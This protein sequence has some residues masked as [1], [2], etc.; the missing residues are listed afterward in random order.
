LVVGDELGTI[1]IVDL[2]SASVLHSQLISLNE[3]LWISLVQGDGLELVIASSNRLMKIN[4]K[5]DSNSILQEN[6]ESSIQSNI[7]KTDFNNIS[8][9]QGFYDV[10]S[11]YF[12]CTSDNGRARVGLW[13][14]INQIE[15]EHGQEIRSFQEI[16]FISFNIDLFLYVKNTLKV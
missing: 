11:K 15:H 12:I 2:K 5:L 10:D 3:R 9:V 16:D 4:V 14:S 6:F 13:S 8:Y 7:I 1:H